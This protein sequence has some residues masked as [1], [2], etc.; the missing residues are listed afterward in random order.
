MKKKEFV[1]I[2]MYGKDPIYWSAENYT[3]E[4]LKTIDRFLDELNEHCVGIE[5]D[6]IVIMD[7]DDEEE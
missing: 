3:D 5:I 6:T 1:T 2:P 7:S 4:E